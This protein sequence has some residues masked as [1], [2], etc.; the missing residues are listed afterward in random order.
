MLLLRDSI[1]VLGLGVAGDAAVDGGGGSLFSFRGVAGGCGCAC[2][3]SRCRCDDGRS[4]G[5]GVDSL[6]LPAASDDGTLVRGRAGFAAGGWPRLPR[7]VT[8]IGVDGFTF[9]T[10]LPPGFCGGLT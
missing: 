7:G 10:K 8:G 1:V 2:R 5:S 6:G 9:T 4:L 3:S